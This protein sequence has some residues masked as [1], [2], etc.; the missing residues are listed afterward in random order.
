MPL[1]VVCKENKCMKFKDIIEGLMTMT[2]MVTFIFNKKGLKF[3][4]I[5]QISSAVASLDLPSHYF[6]LYRCDERAYNIG[7]NINDF[8]NKCSKACPEEA[9]IFHMDSDLSESYYFTRSNCQTGRFVR[10]RIPNPSNELARV[11]YLARQ[12]AILGYFRKD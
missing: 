1:R 11:E 9:I 12:G 10:H 3:N 6:N 4:V 8:K 7:I 2:S 5:D